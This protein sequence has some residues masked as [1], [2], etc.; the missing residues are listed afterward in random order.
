MQRKT[1]LEIIVAKSFVLQVS[2][3]TS[4]AG[5]VAQN[6]WEPLLTAPATCCCRTPRLPRDFT[7]QPGP[8]ELPKIVPFTGGLPILGMPPL[9][10][11]WGVSVSVAACSWRPRRFGGAVPSRPLTQVRPGCVQ[12]RNIHNSNARQTEIAAGATPRIA[13]IL[14]PA[15]IPH[16]VQASAVTDEGC[17]SCR[18]GRRRK[19][20]QCRC[21]WAELVL[22]KQKQHLVS[23]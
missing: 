18:E 9:L 1:W 6:A 21:V 13:A 2:T 10:L 23:A 12:T 20:P 14:R 22:H 15:V 19:L 5:R 8:S 16:F 7:A 17:D 4:L 11:G 3:L